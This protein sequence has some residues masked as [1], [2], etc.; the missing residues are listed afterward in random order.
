M[1]NECQVGEW[2]QSAW[3]RSNERGDLCDAFHVNVSY[4][5]TIDHVD[6]GIQD[7]R[8]WFD[9]RGV[10]HGWAANADHEDIGAPGNVGKIGCVGM[11]D[12]HGGIALH[13]YQR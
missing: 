2:T 5:F 3:Y 11:A 8:S 6:A 13:Q 1:A 12:C 4:Y 9:H 7:N 10:D